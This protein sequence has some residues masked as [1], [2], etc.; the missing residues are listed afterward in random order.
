MGRFAPRVSLALPVYN[1]GE[2][3]RETLEA[4]RAQT[5]TDWELVISDNGS[6]D[7][8]LDIIREFA[9]M[10][11][12]ISY[13]VHPENVGAHRN[14]NSIVPHVRGE[15]FKWLAH[16]D[17]IAPTFIERCVEILDAR[18]EVVLVFAAT[19]RIDEEG[20]VIGELRTTVSYE[21]DS[22]YERLCAYIGDR[23]KSPQIFGVMRRST[24]LETPLLR[25]YR[26][27][28]FTFLQEMSMR[29]RFAYIDEPLFFYR[30]HTRR[31]S[32]SSAEEQVAWYNP[33]Q[34][35]PMMWHWS[36]LGGL[37][38]AIRRVPMGKGDKVRSTLFAGWWAFRHGGD[39]A[40]EVWVRTQYEAG[41]LGSKLRSG[42]R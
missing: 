2:Y 8:T 26:A 5:F 21:S 35:V 30:F 27:S 13:R 23:M 11:D 40:D 29:G 41:R 32:A 31:H 10:D 28:D 38:D 7:E 39:L 17:V 20:E 1:G 33:G 25:S 16:D 19:V 3:L 18:P 42:E 24:L 6:T 4:V 37:L 9:G 12:R 34:R 15:Y 22:P 14:Y 36:Q